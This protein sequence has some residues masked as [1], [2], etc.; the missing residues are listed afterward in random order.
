[1]NGSPPPFDPHAPSPS[2]SPE[3]SSGESSGIP[4]RPC[5][6]DDH[7]A[8]ATT[9]E[10]VTILWT[11]V[12]PYLH[13]LAAGLLLSLVVSAMGLAGPMVT[14]WVLDTLDVGGSLR[15]PVLLLLALLVIG[16]VVG[17]VQWVMLGRSRRR[18]RKSTRLNSSHVA[19]SY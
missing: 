15:D 16:A 2:V 8:T 17:C 4:S 19:S 5:G 14:K 7:E 6:A 18:D 12:R 9:G 11:F 10:R 1:M 3:D 13:V